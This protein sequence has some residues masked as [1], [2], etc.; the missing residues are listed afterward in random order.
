M[1]RLDITS[2][3]YDE[4]NAEKVFKAAKLFLKDV[5]SLL[6]E[7]ERRLGSKYDSA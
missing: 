7:L 4:D 6:A 3:N 1:I 5:K 2:H